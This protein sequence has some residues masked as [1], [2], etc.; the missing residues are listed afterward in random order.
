MRL[1]RKSVD[2]MNAAFAEALV[3][4]HSHLT[5]TLT[6]PDPDDRHGLAAAIEAEVRTIVTLNLKDF[7]AAA[8][9]K[10]HIVAV[11]PDAFVAWLMKNDPTPVERA[12]AAQQASLKNPPVSVADLLTTLERQGMVNPPFTQE[13]AWPDGKLLGA[14]A[15]LNARDDCGLAELVGAWSPHTP[16]RRSPRPNPRARAITFVFGLS[17]EL[18]ARRHAHHQLHAPHTGAKHSIQ[19]VF[20]ALALAARRR[21]CGQ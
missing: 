4:G 14:S 8:L 6:L 20:C 10:H 13:K 5:G 7:P 17:A 2:A 19:S 11:H 1:L 9:A 3:T 15:V 21:S 16:P 18:G 12:F